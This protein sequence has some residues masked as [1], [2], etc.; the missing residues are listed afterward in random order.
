MS[1]PLNKNTDY[2]LNITSKSA[3][4]NKY[5]NFWLNNNKLTNPAD[6]TPN[7]CASSDYMEYIIYGTDNRNDRDDS[8]EEVH[9]LRLYI[10]NIFLEILGIKERSLFLYDK[11]KESESLVKFDMFPE[12]PF[13]YGFDDYCLFSK[14]NLDWLLNMYPIKDKNDYPTIHIRF[15]DNPTKGYINFFKSTLTDFFLPTFGINFVI[16][17]TKYYA[18]TTK[19]K[20]YVVENYDAVTKRNK[21]LTIGMIILLVIIILALLRYLSI[22]FGIIF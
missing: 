20:H 8:M 12:R 14:V 17:D 9:E 16:N 3:D 7:I 19:K 21:D 5:N 4:C 15:T 10:M 2:Y 11:S 6:Y 13:K 1:G 22:I 18:S